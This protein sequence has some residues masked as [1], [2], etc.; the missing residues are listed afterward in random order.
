[1]RSV[2]A[3]E[4]KRFWF[5]A[6]AGMLAAASKIGAIDLKRCTAQQACLPGAPRL[7]VGGNGV[8]GP[9]FVDN[10]AG[11]LRDVQEQRQVAQPEVGEAQR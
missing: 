2:K 5:D 10:A 9:V 6:D 4:E 11:Q 1:M 8:S 7:V 3:P